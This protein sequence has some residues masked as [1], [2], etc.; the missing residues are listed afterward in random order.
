MTIVAPTALLHECPAVTAL[1]RCI[2][3]PIA[4]IYHGD[5]TNYAAS[6]SYIQGHT[7]S[8]LPRPRC[9]TPTQPPSSNELPI[10][11]RFH[12][13]TKNSS[14]KDA[15]VTRRIR[16]A[17]QVIEPDNRIPRRVFQLIC[18]DL[19]KTIVDFSIIKRRSRSSLWMKRCNSGARDGHHAQAEPKKL[20]AESHWPSTP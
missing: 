15:E 16:R 20:P 14:R 5:W 19:D 12:C 8:F 9:P 3:V 17:Y 1:I 4:R 11:L 10:I 18:S 2:P 6:S 7:H 13:H